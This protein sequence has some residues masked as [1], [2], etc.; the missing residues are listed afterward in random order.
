VKAQGRNMDRTD[1]VYMLV[2]KIS[3]CL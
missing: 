2:K 3:W 1:Q